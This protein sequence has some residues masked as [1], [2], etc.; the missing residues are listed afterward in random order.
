MSKNPI[1]YQNASVLAKLLSQI[2]MS[3]PDCELLNGLQYIELK[4]FW[5]FAEDES[6]NEAFK[7]INHSLNE[8]IKTLAI[9]LRDDHMALFI[10]CG[11]PLAPLWGSV[12][13]NQENLLQRESTVHLKHFLDKLNLCCALSE[14]HPVDNLAICLSA[15]SVLLERA[16][17]DENSQHLEDIA[18]L[19]SI[20][21]CPW[22]GRCLELVKKNATSSFYQ[23]IAIITDAFFTGL[24]HKTGGI[25]KQRPLYY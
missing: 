10:G 13:L 5:T 25:A 16:F 2:Y 12:Y 9:K 18:L 21:I 20:H 24:L 6:I 3:S 7:V 11:M 23:S 17:S 4:E 1:F 15:L 8:E 14:N 22:S 19:L